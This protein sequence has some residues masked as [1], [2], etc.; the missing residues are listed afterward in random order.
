M[1][2]LH[3]DTFHSDILFAQLMQANNTNRVRGD[4]L[5]HAIK[6]GLG[7]VAPR[8]QDAWEKVLSRYSAQLMTRRLEELESTKKA[9]EL[10]E[11]P[12]V[13]QFEIPRRDIQELQ[14]TGQKEPDTM[15]KLAQE[16]KENQTELNQSML[17]LEEKQA[18]D[19]PCL[20]TDLQ[21][22]R[23]YSHPV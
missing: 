14:E 20:T 4:L 21:G 23:E 11:R 12:G 9:A 8:R 6:A 22:T 17:R 18:A 10:E 3:E 5:C 19:I 2:L 15:T 7:K 1:Q 13:A 16:V